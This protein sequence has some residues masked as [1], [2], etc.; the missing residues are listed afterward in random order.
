ME[1]VDHE[2]SSNELSRWN[3][4]LETGIMQYIQLHP[5]RFHRR[6]RR[7]IP[8]QFRWQ[9]WKAIVH[10]EDYQDQLPS[11]ESYLALSSEPNKWTAQIEIDICRTFPEHTPFDGTQQ[12]RLQRVLNAYA[13]Y[14]Q[15]VG[16]CQGMN[17]VAGLLLL[18]SD[19][20]IE[21]FAVFV[22][23]MDHMGLSGFYR[24]RLP[25]LRR[26]LRACDKLVAETV[27][28]L[29]EHFIKENVQP[30]VYLHQWFLT[31]FINCFPLSMVM[32]IW[33]VIICEGL[34]VILRIAVSILQVLKDSLL[35]MHFEEIVKFFKMMKTY[36]DEEGEL[37]AF[38][39]G[40]LLMKHTEQVQIPERV[41]EYLDRDPAEDDANPESDESW[42]VDLNSGSWLQSLSRLFTFGS[43]RGRRSSLARCN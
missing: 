3:E 38:R 35:T 7:G 30:A 32:I 33:D 15:S 13:G 41:L 9:V 8:P 39:I 37:N 22:C 1:A 6:V 27:P 12:H 19:S 2:V 36:D 5:D 24:E 14:N 17:Y 29:R 31:L 42:E 16:Y 28:D 23:L 20:E 11:E 4:I 10:V 18:V 40:Q 25:L 34:P 21:S 43:T 26:Y